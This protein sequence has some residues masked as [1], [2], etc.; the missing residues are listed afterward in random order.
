MFL[1]KTH[2]SEVAKNQLRF[3]N[4]FFEDVGVLDPASKSLPISNR[5]ALKFENRTNIN[6]Y[7][8]KPLDISAERKQILVLSN[9]I[10]LHKIW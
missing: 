2:E 6:I 4:Q 5:F 9:L 10:V 3:I 8:Y 1:R 7:G